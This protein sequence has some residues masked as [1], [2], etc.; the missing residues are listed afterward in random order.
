MEGKDTTMKLKAKKLTLGGVCAIAALAAAIGSALPAH[1]NSLENLER[2]RA[3]LI[4]AFLDPEITPAERQAR[5]ET[6][7]QRLIDLERI[8]LRDDDLVGRNTPNVRRAFN[9]YDLTF[10]VHASAERD[11]AI[12]DVWLDELGITTRNL[13]SARMGRR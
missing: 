6:S 13:M 7:K 9:N 4:E 10:L 2:E 11:M 8:V 12:V 1:A 5:I 3:F